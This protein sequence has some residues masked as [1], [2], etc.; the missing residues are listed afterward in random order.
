MIEPHATDTEKADA[1]P[2]PIAIVVSYGLLLFTVG[3]PL[4]LL[5]ALL[6]P[7]PLKWTLMFLGVIAGFLIPS[8]IAALLTRRS[9]RSVTVSAAVLGLVIQP[10]PWMI[11]AGAVGALV[12][13]TAI[14][15]L[16]GALPFK[17]TDLRRGD[18]AGMPLRIWVPITAIALAT[19]MAI[20]TSILHLANLPFLKYAVFPTFITCWIVTVSWVSAI[21]PDRLAV[22]INRVSLRSAQSAPSGV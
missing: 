6:D 21:V 5:A 14:M 2:P 7:N 15:L 10:V 3:I 1:A 18:G 13:G 9:T 12:V 4:F 16:P 20:L 22:L 8:F 17:S 11:L 19:A